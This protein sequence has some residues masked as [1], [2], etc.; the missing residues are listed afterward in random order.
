MSSTIVI[1]WDISLIDWANV[2][3]NSESLIPSRVRVSDL[4]RINEHCKNL[5]HI[6]LGCIWP[7]D[8]SISIAYFIASYGEQLDIAC[9]IIRA[10]MI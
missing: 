2:G 7:E 4:K 6:D 5:K 10:K 9:F 1:L 8:G 3:G